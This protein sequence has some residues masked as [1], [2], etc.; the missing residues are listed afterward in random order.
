MNPIRQAIVVGGGTEEEQMVALTF[1]GF[2]L[3]L[4]LR[5]VIVGPVHLRAPASTDIFSI[6][7][8]FSWV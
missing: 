6:P 2:K 8:I 1:L 4:N 3:T 7:W 5:S